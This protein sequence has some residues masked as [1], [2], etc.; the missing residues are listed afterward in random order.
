[1]VALVIILTRF[2]IIPIPLPTFNVPGEVVPSASAS[3]QIA[4]NTLGEGFK[5]ILFGAVPA[6][7]QNKYALYK[8]VSLNATPLW[9]TYFIQGF[10]AVFTHLTEDGVLGSILWISFILSV[11]ASGFALMRKFLLK[12]RQDYNDRLMFWGII[13]A[14]GFLLISFIFYTQNFVN[15]FML[16]ALSGMLVGLVSAKENNYSEISLTD[17]PYR[18][19]V[20]AVLIILVIAVIVFVLFLQIQH[21]RGSNY[22]KQAI[23]VTDET[24]LDEALNSLLMASDFDSR[25]EV[26]LRAL[27]DAHLLKIKNLFDRQA[28]GEITNP[29]E[30]QTEFIN[31]LDAAIQASQK[32]TEVNKLSGAS[33]INLA[34]TYEN[35]I[36]LVSGAADQSYSAYEEAAKLEPTNPIVFA[37][38]GR[39][40]IADEKYDLAIEKLKK[41]IGLKGNYAPAR[42]WLGVAYQRS[43]DRVEAFKQAEIVYELSPDDPDVKKLYNELNKREEVE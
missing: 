24:K 43:G 9:N 18:P 25:N 35:V 20:A 5:N 37:N 10:S 7:Y 38:F 42:Y 33:W 4:K 28:A 12:R 36:S 17:V 19:L 40:Y 23:A 3:W 41:A 11:I 30:V 39:S 6:T 26:Y 13:L 15:Y 1:M 29:Q 32:A 34:K 21:Y 16:F 31:N 2:N 22:F 8:S 27:S 14:L